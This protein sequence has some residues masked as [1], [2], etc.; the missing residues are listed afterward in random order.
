MDDDSDKTAARNIY[1]M[2]ANELMD[3]FDVDSMDGFPVPGS[4]VT[5]DD[6]NRRLLGCYQD[7]VPAFK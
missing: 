1:R 2:S 7:V 4:C 3:L 5:V 6:S